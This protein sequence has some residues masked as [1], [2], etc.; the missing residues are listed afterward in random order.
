[1]K[2]TKPEMYLK[3]YILHVSSGASPRNKVY[4]WDA[5]VEH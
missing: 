3:S 2:I 1:M 5:A 4:N